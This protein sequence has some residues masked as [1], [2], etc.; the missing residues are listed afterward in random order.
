MTLRQVED[1]TRFRM[2]RGRAM[3][4]GAGLRLALAR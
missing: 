1:V 2:R 3:Q 4:M